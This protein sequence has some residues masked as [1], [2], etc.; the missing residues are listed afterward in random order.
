[1]VDFKGLWSIY[2]DT[3]PRWNAKGY[4]DAPDMSLDQVSS[5]YGKLKEL[6]GEPPQ[7]I[8]IHHSFGSTTKSMHVLHAS[9]RSCKRIGSTGDSL[10]VPVT[11]EVKML[12]LSKGDRVLILLARPEDEGEDD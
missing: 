3:D 9:I 4:C 10:M 1:M 5:A 11:K 12:G 8:E 6:Y 7:D 2:S